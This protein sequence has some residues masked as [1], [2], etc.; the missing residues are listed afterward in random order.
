MKKEIKKTLGYVFLAVIIGLLFVLTIIP[1]KDNETKIYAKQA[2]FQI[3]EIA[4]KAIAV[5][6]AEKDMGDPGVRLY[7]PAPALIAG[8]AVAAKKYN[9]DIGRGIPIA[10]RYGNGS[11]TSAII[12]P[13]KEEGR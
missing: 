6:I 4:G 3:E 5:R 12:Y 2:E 13:L 1:N 10:T 11:K 7:D 8:T 9:I